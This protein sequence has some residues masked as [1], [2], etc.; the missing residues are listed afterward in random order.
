[1]P[2][3]PL[4]SL[5]VSLPASFIPI[6]ISLVCSEYSFSANGPQMFPIN[7]YG[8]ADISIFIDR[9]DSKLLPRAVEEQNTTR[10]SHSWKAL[11]LV[12]QEP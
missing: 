9:T 8:K 11:V 5:L 2:Q 7:A 1:M 12:T 4:M 6:F 3:V 10:T